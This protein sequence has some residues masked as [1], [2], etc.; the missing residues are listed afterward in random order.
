MHNLE[1]W[2]AK[3]LLKQLNGALFLFS[4][5]MKTVPQDKSKF[6]NWLNL[7]HLKTWNNTSKKHMSKKNC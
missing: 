1:V 5:E 6:K 4:G 3:C 7:K 2:E